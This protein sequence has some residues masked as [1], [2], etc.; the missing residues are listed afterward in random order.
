[1]KRYVDI[2]SRVKTGQL[3]AVI[4]SP[5]ARLQ[6][7][8]AKADT[9]RSR[10]TVT[11]SQ[12]D[13]EKLR[14]G[15][16][17]AKADSARAA[18]TTQQSRAMI[19]NAQ[20]RVAQAKANK[21]Q[22]EAKLAAAQQALEGQ[23]AAA[24][25]ADAQLELADATAKRYH[26]LL[27]EG[28][29]TQQD[30]DQAQAGLKIA[31]ANVSVSKSAVSAAAANVQSA[32]EE[33]NSAQAAVEAAEADVRS[34]TESLNAA[35]ASEKASHENIHANE[36]SLRSGQSFVTANRSGVNSLLAAQEKY[37]ALSSFQELRAPF[38]GVITA[39]NVDVGS[40]VAAG[41]GTTNP[42]PS[43]TVSTQGLFGLARTDELRIQVSVPQSYMQSIR[44][45][46]H[47][48]VTVQ[49]L[50]GR[51]FEGV[52]SRQ[53][54]ALDST[55]RTQMT[56]I[57]LKNPDGALLPGMFA[58]VSFSTGGKTA[59]L[60]V[61]ANTLDVGA[62]GTR[63][64]I[65]RPDRTL[66]YV[67]VVLG[68]DYGSEAEVVEGLQGDEKLVTNPTNEMHEGMKVEIVEAPKGEG[69]KPKP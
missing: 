22:S 11:Q 18:A 56:E 38:D 64:A 46:T 10:A 50:P 1:V 7:Q 31:R 55:T 16:A 20:S 43:T 49:E 65:V 68:R 39:R 59:K 33:I 51:K 17:Q 8:Q 40:L 54:G 27:L 2:G 58:N 69:G 29:V 52:V 48:T 35:I 41:A 15:V 30:D 42:S 32:K 61:P 53:S 66:H 21:S 19:S 24:T 67:K 25:Q 44:P 63:I 26:G 3:L 45:G 62:N 60:R 47:A 6:L 37:A 28:F 23:K 13:V 12:S 9:D 14:A 57:R 4:E 34:A 36:A 5:E